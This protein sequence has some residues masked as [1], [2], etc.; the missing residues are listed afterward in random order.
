MLLSISYIY[1]QTPV[2]LWG[3]KDELEKS[4]AF[5]EK[6]FVSWKITVRKEM[7]WGQKL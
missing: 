4:S 3:H 6:S 1:Q 5:I 7:D 2:V